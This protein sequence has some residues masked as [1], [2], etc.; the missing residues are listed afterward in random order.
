MMVYNNL[1]TL[2]YNHFKK[3]KNVS[4]RRNHHRKHYLCVCVTLHAQPI[5]GLHALQRYSSLHH[6]R[7][8][9]LLRQRDSNRRQQVHV[10]DD[11]VRSVADA[12]RRA[13]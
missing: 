3:L 9:V 10:V 5:H 8:P 7:E 6:W 12:R 1:K 4:F 2:N 13:V 11:L